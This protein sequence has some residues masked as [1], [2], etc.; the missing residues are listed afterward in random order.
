MNKFVTFLTLI[1]SL[2]S[3]NETKEKKR[4]SFSAT[5]QEISVSGRTSVQN[6]SSLV[7]INSASAIHFKAKSD[8]LI[9][10]FDL[11]G[12]DHAYINLEIDET[13]KGRFKVDSIPLKF[14]LP[15]TTDFHKISIFKATE[16]TIGALIINKIKAFDIDEIKVAEKPKIEFIGNSIT[17]GMGADTLEIPCGDGEWY[18]QHNA[19]MAYGPRIARALDTDF[20]LNCVSGMGMYRNWNDEDQ[21]VMPDVYENLYLNANSE[22]K[23]N[24]EDSPNII[25][26][27]LGTNDFSL[28]DGEKERTTFSR[29]KFTTSYINFVE[30]LFSKYP[31]VKISLLDSPMLNPEQKAV[32][33]EVFKEI[34]NEFSEKE[35]AIFQFTNIAPGGCTGHP[36]INDHEAMARQLIPFFTNLL[37]S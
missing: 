21:P 27:A 33:A 19:Y 36:D 28:G 8:T 34:Q 37:K 32:L 22:E 12:T 6:D 13:Y 17:C 16:A 30:M 10:D 26:I 25:S 2:S 1:I 11:T 5:L 35:I 20:E 31:D 23:A 9:I 4:T 29:E 18:D 3:C 24:F 7:L 14:S 15:D